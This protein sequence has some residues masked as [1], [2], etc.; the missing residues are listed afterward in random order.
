M[1]PVGV[2]LSRCGFANLSHDM[3]CPCTIS[4]GFYRLTQ[5]FLAQSE[6]TIELSQSKAVDWH[7]FC[8]PCKEVRVRTF[9][10]GCFLKNDFFS[11]QF[12]LECVHISLKLFFNTLLTISEP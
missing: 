11:A 3:G 1:C 5:I 4:R 12:A 10:G 9:S 7:Y 8:T 6:A 2:Q